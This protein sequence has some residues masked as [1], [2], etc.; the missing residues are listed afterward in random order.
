MSLQV[1]K[2]LTLDFYDKK[3]VSINAK[4]YDALS[5]FILVTC[6]NQGDI[7]PINSNS[8]SAYVRYRKADDYGVFNRCVITDDGKIL[9]EL[10]E[11]MLAVAGNCYADLVILHKLSDNND[12]TDKFNE[13]YDLTSKDD[14]NGNV[15]IIYSTDFIDTEDDNN[16][17]VSMDDVNITDII[18]DG[19]Y[20]ILSTMTFCVNVSETAYDNTEI[21]SSY[22]YNA[23][24]DLLIKATEDY[25]SVIT[26]CKTYEV[27][28]KKSE[29]NAKISENN[30]KT[31]EENIAI[32]ESNA[33]ESANNAKESEINAE[34]YA[35]NA[36]TSEENAKDSESVAIAKAKEASLSSSESV[37]NAKISSDK[38]IESLNSALL[39]QS[40]AVGET[41]IRANEN[42]DNAKYYYSQAKA[43]SDSIDGSFLPMGTIKFSQLQSVIKDVGYMYHITD[44]FVTDDAFKCGSG[45][46]YPSG[47]TVY[48]TADGYWDCFVG[49]TLTVVDDGNGIVEFK[50]SYSFVATHDDALSQTIT[51]L[52]ERIKMLEEQNVLGINE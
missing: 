6:C 41:N 27:N 20:S 42:T 17:N 15:S 39:S 22:E 9:V 28:A 32:F 18:T 1:N 37:D 4:Q 16:G 12:N 45:I 49:D 11:Q 34:N 25:T 43:V 21:E 26:A 30:A 46:S 24:N 14:D 35:S 51:E 50:C 10:T 8:N 44:E 47:T 48:Y 33:E 52:Q 19:K 31:S 36:K 29:E 40:Y 13:W 38:A 2:Q 5:R 3:Y 7:F 23:L